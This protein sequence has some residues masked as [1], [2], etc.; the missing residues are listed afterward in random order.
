M[1]K[2]LFLLLMLGA[3]SYYFAHKHV[4]KIIETD[5]DIFATMYL[6]CSN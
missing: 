5:E 2:R 4:Q 3:S 6:D 1:F